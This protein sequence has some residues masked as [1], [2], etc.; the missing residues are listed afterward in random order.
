MFLSNKQI[1]FTAST[2]CLCVCTVGVKRQSDFGRFKSTWFES[3]VDSSESEWKQDQRSWCATTIG[4]FSL[5]QKVE[6][7]R[8]VKSLM[9][10]SVF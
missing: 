3:E 4:K 2:N 8:Q 10:S 7:Y 1:S 5:L 6:I 9:Q